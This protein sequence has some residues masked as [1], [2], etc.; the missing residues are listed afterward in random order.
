[1][2]AEVLD[3]MPQKDFDLAQEAERLEKRLKFLA[4]LARLWNVATRAHHDAQGIERERGQE[5]LAA[6][7]AKAR[8]TYQGLLALLDAIHE[9]EVPKPSGS[10]DSLV[11]FDSRRVTKERL[12]S[13]V[14]STCLDQALAVG[15]LRGAREKETETDE[16][17]APPGWENLVIR[18]E[19]ALL[20]KEPAKARAWLP[21]FIRIF[22]HEPLLYTPLTHGGHPRQILRASM[23]QTI[24]RGLVANLSRQGLVRETYQLV[25]LAH[26]MEQSQTLTGPRVTEFDRLFQLAVQAVAEAVIEAAQRD[27]VSPEPIVQTLENVVEPFLKAWMDHSKTLRVAMLEAITSD[28]DWGR[29]CDF[30]KKYGHDL[31]HAR[32]MTLANLRGILHRGVG[33]YLDYLSEN[34]DPMHPIKLVDDI[35]CGLSRVEPER[36]LQIILQTLIENYDHYRDY[37]TTTTQSDY[38][39]NLYQFFD[40]LRLKASYERNAWQLRP[41]NLVH[42]VLAKKHRPTAKLWRE[43]VQEMCRQTADDHLKELGRLE[44]MHGMRLATIADRLEERFVKPMTLDS[45]CALVEPAMESAPEYLNNDE[46]IPLED[47]LEPLAEIPTGV[48]LDVPQ[49]ILRLEGEV[50]RVRTS[51]TALV[52]LAET[53]FQVP[54][55]AVSFKELAEQLRDWKKMAV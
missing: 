50:Q 54:K 48:G 35:D 27:A 15:A 51:K 3:F 18:L 30:I 23:A 8:K 2:D 9:H 38:G 11:E 7:L 40:F 46:I 39:E 16:A 43:Q 53:L 22:K 31:F 33:P 34:P 4:T 28:K 44:K 42:E 5:T 20:K 1:L 55:V 45:V 19:R 29:L 21:E 25:L 47:A 49:W 17:N 37:N 13:L 6:W 41:L 10:Y 32:F 14:I 24:L 12:L 52:N 26:G 36:W